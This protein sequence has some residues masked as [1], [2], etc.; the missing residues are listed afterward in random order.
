VPPTPTPYGEAGSCADEGNCLTGKD[1][2][3]FPDQ[4]CTLVLSGIFQEKL[5]FFRKERVCN[6]ETQAVREEGGLNERT[7]TGGHIS[8]R[9]RGESSRECVTPENPNGR[10]RHS[11]P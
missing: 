3:C 1:R 5:E 9:P 11:E 7:A 4:W 10:R 6:L 8:T 2:G